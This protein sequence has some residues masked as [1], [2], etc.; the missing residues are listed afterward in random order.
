MWTWLTTRKKFCFCFRIPRYKVQQTPRHWCWKGA[1]AGCA[2]L[3]GWRL[4]GG[5]WMCN[6]KQNIRCPKDRPVGAGRVCGSLAP[7]ARRAEKMRCKVGTCF[8]GESINL[9]IKQR[10]LTCRADQL[11]TGS[12][13]KVTS[14]VWGL[15]S[16]YWWNDSALIRGLLPGKLCSCK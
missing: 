13:G 5:I 6:V 16:L 4:G 10:F 7:C 2:W 14:L 15:P 9:A 11:L 8:R 3:A 1:A 12:A